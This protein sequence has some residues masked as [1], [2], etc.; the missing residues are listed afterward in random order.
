MSATILDILQQHL[1]P[2]VIAQMSQQL[3]ASSGATSNAIEAAL[4]V[5]LAGL[6]RNASDPQGA[7]S[8]DTALGAHDGSVLD[9]VGSMLGTLAASG[10]GSAILMHILGPG[11][12]PVAIGIAR[13]S[14]LNAGQV[15]QLLTM[16]A[17]LVMGALGR[18]K[19]Q[20][21][22]GSAQLPDVLAQSKA[23]MEQA[24]PAL[25]GL[26]NILDGNQAQIADE[27]TRIGASMLG[28]LFGKSS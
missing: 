7:A 12:A 11:V 21:G 28:S 20:Q 22:L 26:G 8:L 2:E 16:L 5:I 24:N 17:P 27:V 19:A 3:G 9:N 14:G 10:I 13:A 18:I 15:S 25:S 4:P 1:T 6:H 23:Q